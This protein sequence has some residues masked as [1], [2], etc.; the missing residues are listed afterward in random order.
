MR[1]N[2]PDILLSFWGGKTYLRRG[3]DGEAGAVVMEIGFKEKW[4]AC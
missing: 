3:A 1:M 4:K 2:T